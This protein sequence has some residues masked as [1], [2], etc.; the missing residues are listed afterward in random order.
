MAISLSPLGIL[1]GTFDPIHNGHLC[2]A[3]EARPLL[4]LER[5]LLIPAGHPP[6]RAPPQ[7]SA[8]DRLAMVRL[9]A[10]GRPGLE[11]DASEVLS[12]ATSYTVDT[13]R[14]LR[15]MHGPQRPLVLLLGADAFLGLASWFQ[16]QTLFALAHLAV[17]ARPDHHC[18]E[19]DLAPP[20]AAEWAARRV[21]QPA[22][23]A[24]APAGAIFAFAMTPVDVS[25]SA[26]RASLA[27]GARLLPAAV[28]HYIAANRL[29]RS[30]S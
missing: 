7:A 28:L 30:A 5:V 29:Y 13:L 3:E 25:A 26:V 2:L 15:A 21:E 9:A 4:G 27:A 17:A 10:T 11:V 18:A 20:L 6:H 24:G 22:A 12:A 16:W 1:G 19:N 14:R 23:L 8:A